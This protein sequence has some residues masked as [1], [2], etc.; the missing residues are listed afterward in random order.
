M[1]GSGLPER[2]AD[3]RRGFAFAGAALAAA[4]APASYGAEARATAL[5]QIWF[6]AGE[7]LPAFLAFCA[8]AAA[9]L[10][11]IVIE[12]ARAYGLSQYA[13]EL[14]MRALVLELVPLLVALFVALRSGAAIATEIALMQTAGDFARMRAEG[15]DPLAR[16]F[17]PRIAAAVL[18]LFALTVLACA[19]VL[20]IAYLAMYG[21]SPWGFEAYTRTI[22]RV[23]SVPILAGFAVQCALFGAAVALLPIAAAL[24]ADRRR[25]TVPVA[26]RTGMVRLFAALALIEVGALGARYLG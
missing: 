6:T 12:S 4:L 2:F 14:V 24:G 1:P 5:R 23:F 3:W 10:T 21:F 22:G 11:T 7:I 18:S 19:L 8:L 20:A 13:L 9:V 25:R 15:R 16:E 17:A 26:V